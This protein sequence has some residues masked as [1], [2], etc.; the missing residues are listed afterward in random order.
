MASSH[1]WEDQEHCNNVIKCFR[2]EE[3]IVLLFKNVK[4]YLSPR[5]Y[6]TRLLA[7][8]SGCTLS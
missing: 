3:H 1:H 4:S 7:I 6:C 2:N 8:S 5:P